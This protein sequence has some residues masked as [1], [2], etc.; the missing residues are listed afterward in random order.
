MSSVSSAASIASQ[1]PA[2][3]IQPVRAEADA[4]IAERNAQKGAELTATAI[5][6]QSAKD[7][8]KGLVVDIQV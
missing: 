1:P 4:K 5:A 8:R 3:P 2:A 7:A 6:A